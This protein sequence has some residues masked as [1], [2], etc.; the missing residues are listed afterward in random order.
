MPLLE[1]H[2]P[3][4]KKLGLSL[5]DK[6]TAES[7]TQKYKEKVEQFE[8]G[9]QSGGKTRQRIYQNRLEVLQESSELIQE[10]ILF[11]E[12]ETELKAVR[13]FLRDGANNKAELKL[14]RVRKNLEKISDTQL[15]DQLENKLA[16]ILDSQSGDNTSETPVSPDEEANIPDLPDVGGST[17]Q[18]ASG[19]ES[20]PVV[21]ENE[22]TQDTETPSSSPDLDEKPPKPPVLPKKIKSIA[23][24]KIQLDLSGAEVQTQNTWINKL[25]ALGG[26][27]FARRCSILFER[28]IIEPEIAIALAS[29]LG[30]ES[31]PKTLNLMAMAHAE[32]QKKPV[33]MV[34]DATVV[35]MDQ[36]LIASHNPCMFGRGRIEGTA[37]SSNIRFQKTYQGNE[38]PDRLYNSLSRINLTVEIED[39]SL[40][41]TDGYKPE[42]G[43]DD[44]VSQPSARGLWVNGKR[45]PS[46]TSLPIPVEKITKEI[47]I[48]VRSSK[49]NIGYRMVCLPEPFSG[50]PGGLFLKRMDSY[51]EDVIILRSVVEIREQGP[52]STTV[53]LANKSLLNI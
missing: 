20:R 25:D 6:L 22:S 21:V 9:A 44:L 32:F 52:E 48:E 4:L 35:S 40:L 10:I 50:N 42:A 51:G 31:A 37:I 28:S 43:A 8:S 45:L 3:H 41:V 49:A 36:I 15:T 24:Q 7:I 1:S 14:S 5:E 34:D 2:E 13:T 46:G 27:D 17:E 19:D 53:L 47:Q 11:F 18:D 12:S 29:D 30:T 16:D 39:R 38:M 23:P 26:N 33:I